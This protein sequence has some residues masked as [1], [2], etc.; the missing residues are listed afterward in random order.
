MIQSPCIHVPSKRTEEVDWATPLKKYIASNYQDDPEK[1]L[2]EV[3]TINR[4]RQDMRGAGK[5]T[6]GRDL[7]YRYYG[8]LELLDLRFPVD[9]N[10]I[11]ISFTWCDTFT[12]KST[13]QFSLAYEKACTIFN[14]ASTLSAIASSQ[15]RSEPDG[16]KR[17]FNYFQA[18]AG[19]F[20]YINE[21]F[22]HAPSTDLSRDIVKIL[23]QL[24]LAQAQECFLEKSLGEKKK[25]ALIAK[26]ASQASWSYGSVVDAMNEGVA[27]TALSRWWHM[28]CQAKQKHY[29]AVAQYH[30]AL[31]CEAENKYGE[32]VARLTY[33]ETNAKEATKLVNTFASGFTPSLTSIPPD[34]ATALQDIAKSSQTIISEKLVSATKDNDLVYH[35]IVPNVDVLQ[36]IDKLNAVKPIPISELYGPN[37]IQKV[38]GVDIFQRLIPLSVHESSSLYSEE[39]AKII[40]KETERVDL[41]DGE[42]DAALS[43]MQLPE[44]IEKFK[45]RNG[46]GEKS[47]TSLARSTPE[48]KEWARMISQ[49]ENERGMVGELIVT[50]E[51]LRGKAKELLDGVGISLEQEQRDCEAMRVKFGDLWTQSPSGPLTASFRQDIRTHREALDKAIASD[52]TLISRF[53]E[54]HSSIEVLREGEHSDR[55]EQMFAE[56]VAS[57]AGSGRGSNSAENSLLDTEMEDGIESNITNI[58]KSIEKLNKIKK[59]RQETLDDLKKKV[60]CFI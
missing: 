32:V 41:A 48:V 14:M 9:E 5:D 58:E 50:L 53:E 35:D 12:G 47:I 56:A 54:I 20:T 4:L 10:N 7:L 44:S 18:S 3:N 17:A 8:Q 30:K 38:I 37:E 11:K 42:L 46:M 51:G 55:L 16:L 39:K 31:A 52:R 25:D 1:Y 45:N 36:P 2:E 49:E 13:S 60:G 57:A 23:S 40:R 6:T 27:K 21:N 26:L 22:L 24:M 59:E 28:V 34:A 19:M 29:Q 33:A 43:F 15:V